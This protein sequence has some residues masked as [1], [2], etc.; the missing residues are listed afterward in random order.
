MDER[1]RTV[2]AAYGVSVQ[3]CPSRELLPRDGRL[4]NLSE[5]GAGLLVGESHPLG[6]QVTVRVP[7]PGEEHLLT[8]TGAIRWSTPQSLFRRHHAVGLEWFPLEETARH[9]LRTFLDDRAPSLMRRS[10]LRR[11]GALTGLAGVGIAGW[12]VVSVSR[13][14]RQLVT[15]LEQ[16]HAIMRQLEAEERRSL[17]EMTRLHE[18][19]RFLETS[20]VHSPR[21][22]EPS[23]PTST[24]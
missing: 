2:R 23:P 12:M 21:T 16:R 8:L 5:R 22:P 1:R 10:L 3:Y 6:E 24:P 9:R 17:A 14:N 11:V 4:I 19:V 15:A 13:E 18:E 20:V 7:L